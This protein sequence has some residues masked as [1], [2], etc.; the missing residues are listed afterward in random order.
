MATDRLA[1]CLAAVDEVFGGTVNADQPFFDLGGNSLH[2]IQL[3]VHVKDRAG[4]DI[5]TFDL[6]Q[7][8]SV[9]KFF[10][11]CLDSE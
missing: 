5:N 11:Y 10:R 4:L 1:I 3:T 9:E 6:V 7:A 2:A 8:E